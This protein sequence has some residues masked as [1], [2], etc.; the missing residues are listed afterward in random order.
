MQPCYAKAALCVRN[1]A[2]DYDLQLRECPPS[3]VS[4][5]VDPPASCDKAQF[6]LSHTLEGAGL[7]GFRLCWPHL[8]PPWP[9]EYCMRPSRLIHSAST[10]TCHRMIYILHW[11]LYPSLLTCIQ[12]IFHQHMQWDVSLRTGK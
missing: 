8:Q 6:E 9:A 4:K 5:W 7:F 11:H 10:Q 3:C 2:Y 12:S 1:N